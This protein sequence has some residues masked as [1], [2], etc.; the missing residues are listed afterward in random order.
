MREDLKS[1]GQPR[2]V[3]MFVSKGILQGQEDV[4]SQISA[5]VDQVQKGE[6]TGWAYTSFGNTLILVSPPAADDP[7][8]NEWEVYDLQ[9]RRSGTFT[10]NDT[11]R[12]NT[13]QD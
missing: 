4:D 11:P 12:P 1:Y 3:D 13:S 8:D 5:L 2:G 10:K 6:V 7:S 9:I